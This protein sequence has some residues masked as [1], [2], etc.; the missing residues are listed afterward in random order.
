MADFHAGRARA[1]ES[2]EDDLMDVDVMPLAVLVEVGLQVG[3]FMIEPVFV[4]DTRTQLPGGITDLAG[5]K[6]TLFPVAPY[7]A[8]ATDHITWKPDDIAVF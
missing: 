7:R 6:T 2:G 8:I 4:D 3:V 5:C 1:N